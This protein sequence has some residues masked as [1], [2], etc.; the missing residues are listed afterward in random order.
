[1]NRPPAERDSGSLQINGPAL[2]HV[3]EGRGRTIGQLARVVGVSTSFLAALER[4]TRRGV[5]PSVFRG[6][7][8]ELALNDPRVVLADPYA[9]PPERLAA[10]PMEPMANEGLQSACVEERVP[11]A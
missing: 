6:L 2:R 4:G 5:R 9:V 10:W 11:A 7:V 8:A 3:R 1:M